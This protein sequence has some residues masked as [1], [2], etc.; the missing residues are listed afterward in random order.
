MFLAGGAGGPTL[1]RAAGGW[2]GSPSCARTEYY[3]EYHYITITHIIYYYVEL[4]VS[5]I[6]ILI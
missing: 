5:L 1:W 4:V 3:Y 6:L 2:T